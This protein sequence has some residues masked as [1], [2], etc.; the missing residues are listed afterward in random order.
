M[1]SQLL[2][3]NIKKLNDDN[4]V[5]NEPNLNNMNKNELIDLIINNIN[6]VT[7]G[8]NNDVGIPNNFSSWKN[9]YK[10]L[11]LIKNNHEKILLAIELWLNITENQ[12]IGLNKDDELI[13]MSFIYPWINNLINI[14]KSYLILKSN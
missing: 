11:I 5:N 14:K 4:N 12:L 6:I 1:T 13:M 3:F 8:I 9:T 7:N 2:N 10:G